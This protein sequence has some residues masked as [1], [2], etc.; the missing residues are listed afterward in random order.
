MGFVA[1]SLIGSW[2]RRQL[3]KLHDQTREFV[4]L[5]A[6]IAQML[7]MA[8]SVGWALSVIGADIGWLTV[9]LIASGLL[10]VLAARPILEGMGASAALV[11]RFP[12]C[13]NS[14]TSSVEV[15]AKSS[16]HRRAMAIR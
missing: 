6:R 15:H 3:R 2:R 16:D 10:I 9:V 11:T 1:A 8:F 7:V 14:A 5:G 12:D 13:F 4:G